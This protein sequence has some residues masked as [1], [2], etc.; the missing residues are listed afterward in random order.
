MKKIVLTFGLIAGAIVSALMFSTVPL[1]KNGLIDSDKSLWLGYTSMV[2]SLSVI[3]FGVKSYRDR[4][5]NGSIT[6]GKA[7]GVG[8]LISVV[9]SVVY[10][11]G[12]EFCL[13]FFYP[14]FMEEYMAIYI[15]KA[16]SSGLTGAEL[17]ETIAKYDEAK[18][19]YK[20]PLLRFAITM[21]EPLP[22]G[23]LISLISAALLR[24]K[25]FLATQN[26]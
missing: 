12:W 26:A 3:F 14:N 24:K 22:V 2:I 11:A 21:T 15:E 1:W 6:F 8:V 4:D 13:H 10:A 16:K 7:I 18:E 17:A 5:L 25:S 20:N 19:M 9:A 23:V